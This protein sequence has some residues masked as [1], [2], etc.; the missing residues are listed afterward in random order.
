M[1]GEGWDAAEKDAVVC[2]RGDRGVAA[3][4]DRFT[5]SM[6]GGHFWLKLVD[7]DLFLNFTPKAPSSLVLSIK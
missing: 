5:P 2:H 4:E 3:A 7:N 6:A 1:N